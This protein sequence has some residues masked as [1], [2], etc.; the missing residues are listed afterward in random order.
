[1]EKQRLRAEREAR[2]RA[3]EERTRRDRRLVLLGAVAAAAA[4]I[5]GVAIAVS[6]GGGGTASGRGPVSGAA[7]TGK[8]FAGIPERGTEL[9]SPSAPVTL[10]EYA[11]LRCP[12][13][14]EF[15]LG[16]FPALVD[17]YVRTGKLRIVFRAQTFVGEQDAPGDSERAARFA[18][19]AGEQNRLWQFADLFYRNQGDESTTYVTDAFLKRLGGAVPGLDVAGALGQRSSP[20]VD[21]E[22]SLAASTFNAAGFSGTPSFQIGRTGKSLRPLSTPSLSLSEF[23]SP[24]DS[25]LQRG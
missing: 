25:L 18:L 15:T 13:C 3:A 22:L 9:G 14:R 11:D 24:I 6:S 20:S 19:A 23:T 2:E 12:V 16:P 7:A 8:L 4:V 1:V 17:R 5:V 21:K 10:V